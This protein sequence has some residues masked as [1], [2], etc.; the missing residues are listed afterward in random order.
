MLLDQIR[1]LS[2]PQGSMAAIMIPAHRK[3]SFLKMMSNK[4]IKPVTTL[5]VRQTPQHDF[6]RTMILAGTG[7]PYTSQEEEEISIKD[8]I[9]EY[10]EAFRKLLKDYYLHL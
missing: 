5:N 4:G 6:F 2:S 1:R 10:T 9:G 3:E 7:W 8:E